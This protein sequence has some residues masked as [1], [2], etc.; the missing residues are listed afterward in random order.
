MAKK[1]FLLTLSATGQ[2]WLQLQR[3]L[4]ASPKRNAADFHLQKVIDLLYIRTSYDRT[5][6]ILNYPFHKQVLLGQSF[7]FPLTSIN[8]T[9]AASH[10]VTRFSSNYFILGGRN[11]C[12]HCADVSVRSENGSVP[13]WRERTQTRPNRR[14]TTR[15]AAAWSST[16][17][18]GD[19][20]PHFSC[21]LQFS[22]SI[23]K[24]CLSCDDNNS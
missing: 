5:P 1:K 16:A 22:L 7:V 6:K 24:T 21:M 10:Y 14:T 4:L 9:M 11:K 15:L 13:F 17:Q 19:T 23:Q 8:L 12:C 20:V 3:F 2:C 18:G